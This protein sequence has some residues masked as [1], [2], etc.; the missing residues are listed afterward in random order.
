LAPVL[1]IFESILF[2]IW[3]AFW[4][5]WLI[6]A[7]KT[8]SPVKTRRSALFPLL[9]LLVVV[10]WILFTNVFPGLLFIR[11]VPDNILIGLAGIALTLA[12][13][14]FAIWARL[15]LGTNWSGQPVIRVDHSLVRTGPYSIVRHPI[16]TGLLVAFAGTA[17]VIGAFWALL[18]LFILLIVL[19]MKIRLEEKVLA[20]EFGES[21][22]QYK[23]EVKALVPFIL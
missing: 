15:H 23:K 22:I 7:L 1:E 16:Y 17:L 19:W 13:L 20:E 18:A 21:Y 2:I 5:F 10:L 8:R 6:L 4:S 9:P 3:A 14:G 11:I 12:G